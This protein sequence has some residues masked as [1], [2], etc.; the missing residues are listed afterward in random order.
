MKRRE[1]ITLVGGA[2]VAWPLAVRAQQ[3]GRNHRIG[4]LG[5]TSYAQYRHR[6]DALRAGLRQLGYEQEYYN[7][8]SM[9]RGPII[10]PSR[11]GN[12]AGKDERQYHRDP[13]HARRKGGQEATSTIP[14]V[15]IS[16][17]PVAFGLVASL[18]SPGGNHRRGLF[19]R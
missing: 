15:A 5:M 10:P 3:A 9:G 7:R 1:F 17:D 14:I 19:L 11:A 18:H 16:G 2:A 8:V 12:R 6:V 13:Q 4:F